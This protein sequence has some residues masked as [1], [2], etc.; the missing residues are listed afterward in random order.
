MSVC[1]PVCPT[2]ADIAS[3]SR[4]CPFS[5]QSSPSS[6]ARCEGEL[7]RLSFRSPPPCMTRLPILMT[8]L[9]ERRHAQIDLLRGVGKVEK[10]PTVVIVCELCMLSAECLPCRRN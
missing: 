4:R 1:F 9:M 8:H 10:G 7:C 2:K 6:C 3:L 5:C